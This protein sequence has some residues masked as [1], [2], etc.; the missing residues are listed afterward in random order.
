MDESVMCLAKIQFNILKLINKTADHHPA[1]HDALKWYHTGRSQETKD[2]SANLYMK[3]ALMGA[4]TGVNVP[5]QGKA[6][7]VLQN[8]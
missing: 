2:L 5:H 6:R 7:P 1:F 3:L 4:Q 8:F